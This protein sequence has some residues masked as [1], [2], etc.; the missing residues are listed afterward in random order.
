MEK[1]REVAMRLRRA[2]HTAY[3]VGGAVRDMLLGRTPKDVDVA[4][5]ATPEGVI[6]LFEKTIPTGI[7]HGTV[8]VMVGDE[9]VEVTTF[10]TESGYTDKRRP[11]T[12]RF[13]GTIEEDLARRD[14]TINAMAL[15]PASGAIVDPFGGQ[16]D[17]KKRVIRAVGDA[18][19][20]FSEDALRILRAVRFACKLGFQIEPSTLKAA[21][22][23][24]GNLNALSY[25]RIANE[26]MAILE[27]ERAAYGVRLLA[28][29]GALRVFLPEVDR[30]VGFDQKNPHHP[31][32]L[33]EH[34]LKVLD[35]CPPK[36]T[37][38]LGALL[39]DVGKPG[40]QVVGEDGIAHYYDHP[41]KGAVLADEICRRLRLPNAVRER[42]VFLVR[43]HMIPPEA[44]PRVL[45]RLVREHGLEAVEELVALREADLAS[46][47]DNP[48]GGRLQRLLEQVRSEGER[49]I[50]LAVNGHDLMATLGIPEG[51][52]V[53]RILRCLRSAVEEDPS[54]NTREGLLRLARDCL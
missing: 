4:T 52:E 50:Q 9:P 14:F 26:L 13:V 31:D 43:E 47:A 16:E 41:E 51:P 17:L 42:V 30:V 18:T 20:R 19:A 12:V 7:V 53:G 11:D 5:S 45:R 21:K 8:T 29:I 6:G 25:E 54:R 35:A 49:G 34:T 3:I 48:M 22:D 23:L 46:H 28:E 24:I 15:D 10:R 27:T 36:G 37:L 44:G 38:R 32:D 33:F 39:H 40:A 2:G 1:A